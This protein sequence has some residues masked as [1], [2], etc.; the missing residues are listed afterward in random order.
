MGT[1]PQ[2]QR[3]KRREVV[4]DPG[5]TPE[6]NLPALA[7]EVHRMHAQNAKDAT[8]FDDTHNQ[9]NDHAD[10]LLLLKK[11]ILSLRDSI[12]QV[13]KDVVTNDADLKEKLKD[14]ETIVGLTPENSSARPSSPSW[15][16][17]PQR[18]PVQESQSSKL[19]S[20]SSRK[21]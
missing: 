19:S 13:S 2:A 1:S 6:V 12:A 9:I 15:S 10:C 17:D 20:R 21:P 7:Q 3:A 8:F 18:Q 4:I 16:L 5:P 11:Q 14:L